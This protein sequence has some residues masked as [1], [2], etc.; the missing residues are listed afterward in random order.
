ML[1]QLIN[2]APDILFVSSSFPLAFHC[3]M[4]GLTMVQSDIIFGALDFA[5]SILTHDCMDPS[6]ALTAPKFPFYA[7]TI[8]GAV[9]KEGLQ[10]IGCILS[11]FTSDFPEDGASTVVSIFRH[12]VYLFPVHLLTWLPVV[13]EQLPTSTVPNVAKSQFLQ[14]VTK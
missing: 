11:G 6:T 10:F 4:A 7:A 1:L 14:D 8:R 13:L 5:R 9:E 2:M 3:V 12:L